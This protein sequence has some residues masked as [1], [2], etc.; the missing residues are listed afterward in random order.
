MRTPHVSSPTN[1]PPSLARRLAWPGTVSL[2]LAAI[3]AC[4]GSSSG[5]GDN[6]PSAGTGGAFHFAGASSTTAGHNSGTSGSSSGN[7]T[8][9]KPGSGGAPGKGGDSSGPSPGEGGDNA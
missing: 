7:T 9:G 1:V 4:G 5:D 3:A 2:V 6:G 8:G